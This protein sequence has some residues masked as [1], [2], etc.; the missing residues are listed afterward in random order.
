[1][2]NSTGLVCQN[3]RCRK[4]ILVD[5]SLF[6][7]DLEWLQK[8]DLQD[9]EI[10]LKEYEHYHWTTQYTDATPF[11][12]TVNS[13]QTTASDIPQ[14]PNKYSN[15]PQ[16]K[17]RPST[18]TESNFTNS[19]SALT[20]PASFHPN[21]SMGLRDKEAN[22]NQ[23]SKLLQLNKL[24]EIVSD[25]SSVDFPLCKECSQKVLKTL[26]Q[27]VA[28]ALK[29]F[30]GY[31]SFL[32][33][34]ESEKEVFLP[35]DEL[36]QIKNI[37]LEEQKLR[38]A[39][40]DIESQRDT[41]A[42]EMK[43]LQ[44]DSQQ[45]DI[46]EQQYWENYTEFQHELEEFQNE[47]E[48]IHTKLQNTKETLD[49]LKVTNVYNDTFYIW[50]DGHFG[51]INNFRLGRL[52][53]QPVDWNEINAAWG[54]A[55]LLLHTIAKKLNFKFSTYRLLPMGSNSK[56]EKLSDKS[57][58]EL[59][60]SSDISLGRLFWYRRFDT[61]MVAFLQCLSELG[62]Y[63]ESQ[64]RTFKLPYKIDKDKIGDMSIKI[65]FN[66]EETWTKALKYMLTNLKYLLLFASK[67]SKHL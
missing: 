67:H 40:Q 5:E 20:G 63:A 61:G 35:E 57:S 13:S 52:P 65:Q 29:E 58:Y 51:T 10:K 66:N 55:T 41:L 39:I 42:Q 38:E 44:S 6:D 34:L 9:L 59:F 46:I 28:E 14:Q 15:I 1:M 4:P 11:T 43:L 8:N 24:F 2:E 18:F 33:K 21:S 53:S 31:K 12:Q 17:F 23:A 47:H 54:Q 27:Q 25:K 49:K 7:I 36:E 22:S 3:S 30:E 45:I 56:M 19:N 32:N 26:E 48:T 37:E 16:N 60:G 62:D 64:D 50:H